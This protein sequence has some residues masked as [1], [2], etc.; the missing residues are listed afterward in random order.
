MD[1]EIQN[2]DL[3]QSHSLTQTASRVFE[4]VKNVM[5]A[6]CLQFHF[7]FLLIT[8]LRTTSLETNR[9]ANTN[10]DQSTP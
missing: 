4:I 8:V 5:P 7:S 6:Q 1:F 2:R 10:E 3:S 9:N